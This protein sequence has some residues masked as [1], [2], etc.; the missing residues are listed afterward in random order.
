MANE[1][2]YNLVFQSTATGNGA[3]QTA[4]E[5]DR[6]I[7]KAGKTGTNLG[8]M[9]RNLRST[10]EEFAAVTDKA[11]VSEFAFYDLDKAIAKTDGAAAS[12]TTGT[13]AVKKGTANASQSLLLFS[14]GF[15]DAQYGIRGVLN[16]IPGL[17]IALGGTAGLAG[18]ISIAA[19]AGSLLFEWLTKTEEK[20]SD[21]PDRITEIADNMGEAEVDRFEAFGDAIEAAAASTAAL[22]QGW[23]ETSKAEADYATAALSNAEKL[24]TAQRNIAEVLGL[25]VDRFKELDAIAKQADAERKL[26]AEQ[27]IAAENQRLEKAKEEAT[28]LADKLQ[29]ER[30]R[31]DLESANLLRAKAELEVIQAKRGELEKIAKGEA[32][33]SKP[34]GPGLGDLQAFA[35]DQISRPGS[36][37]G[38]RAAIAGEAGKA[39]ESQPFQQALAG[40][41]QRVERLEGLISSL[42]GD[43]GV[44]ANAE[45]ALITAQTK[46]TDIERAVS[47]NIDRITEN[48][49]AD[50]LVAKSGELVKTGEQLA[51]SIQESFGQIETTNQR[52]IAARDALNQA[53]GDGK[54]TADEM[55]ATAV[56]LRTLLG[57][58]QSG[59]ATTNGNVV[60]LISLQRNFAA[61]QTLIANDITNLKSQVQGLQS[62]A[63]R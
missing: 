47:I 21:V 33:L 23:E 11:R 44:V 52:G 36:F 51:A 43:N 1:F 60:E 31:A 45:N 17:I 16:N 8:G 34:F 32:D 18:A 38:A 35:A 4:E 28:V 48:L 50:T 2:K 19:V 5:L 62:R 46:Q 29:A 57:L 6:V 9:N 54:I 49:S 39:L 40:T 20:A 63:T 12:F 27:A 15:E 25:Q 24:A 10:A 30:Q 61:A 53:A 42:T 55:A 3:K 7:D 14:Q 58:I 26:A 59:Q 37:A 41:A 22:K 56:N 13:T